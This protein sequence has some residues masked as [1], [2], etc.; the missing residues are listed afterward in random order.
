V[1]YRLFLT[2]KIPFSKSI[3]HSI[4]HGP[5]RNAAPGTYT[6]VAYYYSNTPARNTATPTLEETRIT[7]PDTLD[8]YPQLLTFNTSGDINLQR[9][10]LYNTGGESIVFT[11]AGEAG[12]RVHMPE[13]P[14]GDYRVLLDYAR[15]PGRVFLFVVATTNAAFCLDGCVCFRYGA[16]SASIPERCY[17]DAAKP[18]LDPSV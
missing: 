5:E 1:R 16:G 9:R 6:S 7:M 10:W 3:H 12:V 4:E 14:D 18:Y 15:T 2:D 13:V 8:L 11:A 17:I